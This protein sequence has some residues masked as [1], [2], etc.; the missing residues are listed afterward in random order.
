MKKVLYL[1]LTLSLMVSSAFG[2]SY[3]DR[4]QLVG[5]KLFRALVVADQ[6][7][8]RKRDADGN[9][10]LA[11]LYQEDENSTHRVLDWL[12]KKTTSGIQ[13]HPVQAR[14][15]NTNELATRSSTPSALFI[16]EKLPEQSLEKLISYANS[17]NIVL[18]S[19]FEGD[20]EAGVFAGVSIEARVRP[21]INKHAMSLNGVNIKPFFLKI[22]KF[23]E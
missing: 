16:A 4:R 5:V 23:H 15:L 18:F 13:S 17:H 22:T 7:L 2:D 1:L 14:S 6:D 10:D 8:S 11:V 21:Y 20:V 3:Q 19:P 12:R 9:I